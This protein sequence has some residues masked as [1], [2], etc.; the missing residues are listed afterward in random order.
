MTAP[1]WDDVVGNCQDQYGLREAQCRDLPVFVVDGSRTPK[2]AINDKSAIDAGHPFLLTAMRNSKDGYLNREL[3][4]CGKSVWNG[5]Q[6]CDEYPFASTFEG[7][8]GA[9]T[10]GVPVAEQRTQF[11]DLGKFMSTG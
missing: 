3:A 6:S 7:G 10:M 2:I 5:P 1:Q 11:R 8:I 9:Q 4:G